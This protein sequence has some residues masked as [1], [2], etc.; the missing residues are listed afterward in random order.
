MTSNTP[1]DGGIMNADDGSPV[2]PPTDSVDSPLV[3]SHDNEAAESESNSTESDDSSFESIFT[4][5]EVI[6]EGLY[7]ANQIMMQNHSRATTQLIQK[8][9]RKSKTIQVLFIVGETGE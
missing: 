4:E 5:I 6:Q 2:N 1:A 8:T 3:V 7:G 9:N